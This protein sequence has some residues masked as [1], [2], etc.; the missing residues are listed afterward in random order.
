MPMAKT[1]TMGD[2]MR[3][4]DL[5]VNATQTTPTVKD[6]ATDVRPG[7]LRSLV[8]QREAVAQL[9]LLC[10]AARARGE[11]VCHLLM[12]GPPGLGKTSL[13]YAVAAEMGQEP[14][15]T[16]GDTLG[17]ETLGKLLGSGK[18]NALVFIDEVHTL[19]K[20]C[21]TL[22][23]GALEDGWV[24]VS[25][26]VGPQRREV[27]PFT[28]VGATTNPGDLSDPLK[29]RFG[30]TVELGYYG[31]SDLERV[32]TRTAATMGLAL[33]PEALAGVADRSHGTPRV[34]NMLLSRLRDY[35]A[36]NHPEL[37]DLVS[38]SILTAGMQFFGIDQFGLTERDRAYL[39]LI[40]DRFRDGPIGEQQLAIQLGMDTRTVREDVE[41]PLLRLGF[42]GRAP[43]GRVLLPDG[44]EYVRE[45]AE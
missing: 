42:I 5:A 12:T 41:P 29:D 1:D 33:S 24:D 19:S 4:R 23:L 17:P 3:T 21:Q 11:P 16:I 9:E 6:D 13:A 20:R 2:M 44:I 45:M 8:G 38:G 7:S 35:L 30:H 34:A 43:R 40:H 28:L 36:V 25:T 27:L 22:L 31:F 26:P 39:R 15:A 32:A 14:F 10:A 37:D 18:R